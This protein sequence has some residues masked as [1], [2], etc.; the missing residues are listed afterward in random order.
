MSVVILDGGNV[1][2]FL[3]DEEAFNKTI[4][5]KFKELDVNADGVL[6]R[7]ELRKALAS[8]RLLESH[9]GADVAQLPERLNALYDSI[10]EGFDTDHNNKVDFD[11]FRAEMKNILNAIADGLG[12]APIQLLLD[13]DSLLKDAAEFQPEPS[14]AS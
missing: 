12:A 14:K 5:Q 9:M 11:E 2:D 7:S 8:L 13:D 3:A 10:F 6:S 4:Q 1:R